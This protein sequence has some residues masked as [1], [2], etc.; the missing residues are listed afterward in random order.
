MK[1]LTGGKKDFDFV[2]W[3]PR[4]IRQITKDVLRAKK[5]DYSAIKSI[6]AGWRTFEN[7]IY[8]IEAS[9]HALGDAAGA[10]EILHNTSPDAKVRKAAHDAALSLQNALVDIEYD[11]GM[12]RAV[13]DYSA[14][15]EKLG[16]PEAKLLADTLRDYRRMGLELPAPQQRRLKANLKKL[17]KLEKEF[18]KNVNEYKDHILVAPGQTQGLP[19]N[20]LKGLKRDRL[21]RYIVTLE[22][23]HLFPFMAN[24]A[25][26]DKRKELADK[27]L[28]RGGPANVALLKRVIALRDANARL[29]GYKTHAQ[30]QLEPRMAK[31]PEKVWRFIRSLTSKLRRPVADDIRQMTELKRRTTGNKGARLEYFDVGYWGNE[32]KKKKFSVDN[33][34]VREYFPLQTVIKGMFSIYEKLLSVRFKKVTGYPV[35]H[36]DVEVFAVHDKSNR[37]IAHFAMDLHPRPNKY[38]H[39]AMFQIRSG[40]QSSFDSGEYIAPLAALVCNFPKPGPG[41]PSLLSHDEVETFFHEFGH[42]MHGVLT[43]ALYMAQSGTNV[44]R[45]FVEAMSQMLENWVWDKKMLGLLSGHYKTGQKLPPDL[46]ANLLKAKYHLIAYATMRQMTLAEVDMLLHTGQGGDVGKLYAKVVRRHTGL[47]LP[48]GDLFVQGFGH[49]MGYDAGYYGYKWS[50]VYAADMFTRFA[51]RGLLDKA[52]GTRYKEWLL[53]RGSSMEPLDLVR[54]FLEREPNMKAFLKE[55]G[56]S[57]N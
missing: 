28:R 32:L 14:K 41:R 23:P 18:Q 26:S 48:K 43:R 25:S 34:K 38:G 33:E 12:Y 15:K 13:R 52:T 11:P 53:E 56:L 57:K 3:N 29:L 44:P 42:V 9:N 24:A 6:P 45:D 10:F 19:E 20:Y 35:W 4:K 16:G 47:R 55:I 22:Y 5:K 1:I 21:G 31:T 36:K 40:R 50:E 27:S 17:A 46:L 54:G 37:T 49:L 7:T 8:A 39:A 2:R 51:R 30:Y